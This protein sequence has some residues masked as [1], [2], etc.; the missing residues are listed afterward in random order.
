MPRLNFQGVFQGPGKKI[1]KSRSFPGIAG[2]VQT[3]VNDE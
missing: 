3:L 1:K 2:V